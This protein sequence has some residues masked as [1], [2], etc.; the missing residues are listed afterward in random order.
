MT[1]GSGC[2]IKTLIRVGGGN[3]KSLVVLVFLAIAAY[4]TLRGLFGTVRVG[5]LEP[6]VDAARR[7][8]RTCR[9][10]SRDGFGAERRAMEIVARARGRRRA[11]RVRAR[12]AASSGSS[13][14]S[15]AGSSSGW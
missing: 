7:R 10:S 12:K 14:I 15:S 5:V 11:R 3:L 6:V 9:R 8:G 4:M 13:T 1:L 2:G